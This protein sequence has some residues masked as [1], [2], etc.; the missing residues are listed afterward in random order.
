[1]LG[2]IV[3]GGSAA[4]VGY[5]LLFAQLITSYGW[6]IAYLILAAMALVI[7]VPAVFLII[8]SP[9]EARY[10]PYGAQEEPQRQQKPAIAAYGWSLTRKQA[11]RQPLLYIAWMACIL[12]SYG[13]GVAG[14]VTPFATMEL[15]QT[16]NFGA[17]VGMFFLPW[18]HPVQPRFGLDQR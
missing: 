2:I 18:G 6:R 3:A 11:F 12:Y 17:R 4:S 5:G 8:K 13:S 1:M 14:F 16:I 9:A 15:G 10:E 7:T